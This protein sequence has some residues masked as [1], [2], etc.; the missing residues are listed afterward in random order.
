MININT[1]NFGFKNGYFKSD[2]EIFQ[3]QLDIYK[4]LAVF[5]F[6]LLSFLFL[7]FRYKNKIQTKDSNKISPEFLKY[8]PLIL[9]FSVFIYVNFDKLV[10]N[11]LLPL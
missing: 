6:I 11:Y 8:T 9:F 1:I 4:N 5:L 7:F 10:T 2:I 3:N